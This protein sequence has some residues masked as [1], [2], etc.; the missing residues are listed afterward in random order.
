VLSQLNYRNLDDDPAFNGRNTTTEFLARLIF[1]RVAE[2][3]RNGDL[4]GGARLLSS[5][6][7]TLHESHIAWASYENEFVR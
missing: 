1:E 2:K 6:R 4:G 7:V 5:M 3:I